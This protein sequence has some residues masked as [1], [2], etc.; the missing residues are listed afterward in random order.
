VSQAAALNRCAPQEESASLRTPVVPLRA[1]GNSFY[2]PELDV[3]RFSLFT[4]F[5]AFTLALLCPGT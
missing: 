3:L 1:P 2:R 5:S 4:A